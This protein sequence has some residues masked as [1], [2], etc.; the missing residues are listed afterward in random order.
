MTEG[1][2]KR[3]QRSREEGK[4]EEK[5]ERQVIVRKSEENGDIDDNNYR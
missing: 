5:E 1:S 4:Q 2:E 3:I